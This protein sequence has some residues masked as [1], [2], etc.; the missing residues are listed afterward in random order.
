MNHPAYDHRH[1]ITD[2]FLTYGN[3]GIILNR[4]AER[5]AHEATGRQLAATLGTTCP[6]TSLRHLVGTLLISAGTALSGAV[7]G[8]AL[9]TSDPRTA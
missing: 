7:P 8:P 4:A 3:D 1:T 5:R 2:D 6:L 9:D